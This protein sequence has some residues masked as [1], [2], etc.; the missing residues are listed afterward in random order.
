VAVRYDI[1]FSYSRLSNGDA[2]DESGVVTQLIEK[3]GNE[4]TEAYASQKRAEIYYDIDS[5]EAGDLEERLVDAVRASEIFVMLLSRRYLHSKW[6]MRELQIFI[7]QHGEEEAANRIFVLDNIPHGGFN[8]YLT[9]LPQ[10]VSAELVEFIGKQA[11][12]SSLVRVER[13]RRALTTA[14]IRSCNPRDF[15][16]LIV[17][18]SDKLASRLQSLRRAKDPGSLA[19]APPRPAPPPPPTP[20]QDAVCVMLGDTS[21]NAHYER[22]RLRKHLSNRRDVRVVPNEPN[23]LLYDLSDPKI[24]KRRSAELIA[25][26]KLFVQLLG[27]TA[28]DSESEIGAFTLMQLEDARRRGLTTLI[29]ASKD[30][31]DDEFAPHEREILKNGGVERVSTR[32][33][34][35]LVNSKIRAITE[36]A[37]REEKPIRG[38]NTLL[39]F[40]AIGADRDLAQ[41][42]IEASGRTFDAFM[43]PKPEG[44]DK[45]EYDS[46]TEQH[47][48][49][50]DRSF[51]V[52]AEASAGWLPRQVRFYVRARRNATSAV[53]ARVI[54]PQAL[55]QGD[56]GFMGNSVLFHDADSDR[57]KNVS[58]LAR[59]VREACDGR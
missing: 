41:E 50:A 5:M 7:E 27:G 44:F 40:N 48:A 52:G 1:F 54:K 32:E 58:E 26:A 16:R 42:A 21:E 45:R 38:K 19:A 8:G 33:F 10:T 51:I 29:W 25:E 34:R 56:I 14:S 2:D 3:L 43:M 53:P 12:I 6:C 35:D 18:L 39:F 24:A 49:E 36:V 4:L 59:L 11:K 47:Y 55:S 9:D 15:Y 22:D 13:K 57:K 31:P 20:A 30:T 17:N 37:K 23:G 46:L 28:D